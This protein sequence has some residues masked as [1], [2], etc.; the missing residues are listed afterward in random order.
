MLKKHN[1]HPVTYTKH[2][3]PGVAE[4]TERVIVPTFIPKA[5]IKAIDVTDLNDEEKDT[6]VSCLVEYN[7]YVTEQKKTIFSFE[8]W[9]AHSKQ[10]HMT[11]NWR[12]FKEDG[13]TEV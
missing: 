4:V 1:I 2:I 3:S 9:C 13:L 6:V 8:D 12:T 5:N 11:V 7:E 10:L